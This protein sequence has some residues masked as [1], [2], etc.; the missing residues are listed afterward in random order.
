MNNPSSQN[1]QSEMGEQI[2]DAVKSNPNLSVGEAISDLCQ[3]PKFQKLLS[4]SVMALPLQYIDADTSADVKRAGA[5]K[6]MV[7]TAVM[8][9]AVV[10]A[11]KEQEMQD[12]A[13]EALMAHLMLN[14]LNPEQAESYARNAMGHP[15]TDS[16]PEEDQ[17]ADE[18]GQKQAQD[19]Q[20]VA[21]DA[22]GDGEQPDGETG[23]GEPDTPQETVEP[24]KEDEA[25]RKLQDEK[26]KDAQKKEGEQEDGDKKEGENPEGEGKEDKQPGQEAGEEPGE[27]QTASPE[28]ETAEPEESEDQN[29]E[30][31][32]GDEGQEGENQGA[33]PEEQSPEGESPEAKPEEEADKGRELA[34]DKKED[35]DKESNIPSK[36]ELAKAVNKIK[37]ETESA[38]IEAFLSGLPESLLLLLI[39]FVPPIN[40]PL[41][42]LAIKFGFDGKID[43]DM[44]LLGKI[45]LMDFD[46]LERAIMIS[47]GV[48]CFLEY[49]IGFVLLLYFFN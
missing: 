36:D 22:E 40:I 6:A 19:A 38:L 41:G 15:A 24:G 1:L 20:A 23:E 7:A 4:D 29:A 14:G 3:H 30:N 35:E 48:A 32:E 37:K 49:I 43:F 13:L 2:K 47:F 9:D 11:Q 39:P 8:A 34:E 10:Q 12:I 26:N 42:I 17:K 16:A 21:S 25:A 5:M 46:A 44:P 27:D 33:S 18:H 28:Q 31:Q 45:K